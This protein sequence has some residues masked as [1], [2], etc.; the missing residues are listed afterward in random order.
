MPRRAKPKATPRAAPAKS[1]AALESRI[2]K[3]TALLDVATA[4]TAQRDL[5]ALLKLILDEAVKVVT[6]DRCSIW[7]VDRDRNELWT[8]GAHGLAQGPKIRLPIG[9]GSARQ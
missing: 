2:K 5:D 1:V 3:L 8:K 7:I 9:A 6:A 4:M